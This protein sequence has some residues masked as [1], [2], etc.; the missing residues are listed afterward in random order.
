MWTWVWISIVTL[1][2]LGWYLHASRRGNLR[3]ERLCV[4]A[5][6]ERTITVTH[7]RGEVQQVLWEQITRIGITTT[8]EGPFLPDVFWGIHAGGD[9]PAAVFPGGATGEQELLAELQRRLPDFRNDQLIAAMQSTSNAFF[10]LWTAEEH[11][12]V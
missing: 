4:V 12:H 6:D 3:P 9:E 8:D 1:V 7:P 10:L 2:V 11:D 5:F